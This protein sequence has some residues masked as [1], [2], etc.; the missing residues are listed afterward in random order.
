MGSH[1]QIAVFYHPWTGP[2]V[3]VPHGANTWVSALPGSLAIQRYATLGVVHARPPLHRI[4]RGATFHPIFQSLGLGRARG[5][6]WNSFAT[7][8]CRDPRALCSA[9]SCQRLAPK[10]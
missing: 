6:E 1:C 10:R 8:F 4:F 7:A 9:K 3:S 5:W 2:P